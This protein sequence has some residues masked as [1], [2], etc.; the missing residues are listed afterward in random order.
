MRPVRNCKKAEKQKRRNDIRLRIA[1]TIVQGGRENYGVVR[2]GF[3]FL[4]PSS[5]LVTTL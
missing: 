5:I 1:A 4:M 2:L 3:A